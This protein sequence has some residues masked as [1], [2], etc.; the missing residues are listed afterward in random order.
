MMKSISELREILNTMKVCDYN[1]NSR[2]IFEK[3]QPYDLIIPRNMNPFK[4][5][6]PLSVSVIQ[7]NIID[8]L[9]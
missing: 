4:E 1:E 3:N 6:L 5:N 8:E 7:L 2:I 9:L